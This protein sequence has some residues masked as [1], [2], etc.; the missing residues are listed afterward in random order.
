MIIRVLKVIVPFLLLFA[1][2]YGAWIIIESRPEVETQAVEKIIPTIRVMSLT[3]LVLSWRQFQYAVLMRAN[4]TRIIALATLARIALLTLGLALGLRYLPSL[5]PAVVAA[6]VYMLGFL[7][8]T[9]IAF[10]FASRLVA[11]ARSGLELTP[12]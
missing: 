10:G 12:S 4:K 3:L 2:V 9:L 6:G 1:G 7:T 8:E 11:R 5:L